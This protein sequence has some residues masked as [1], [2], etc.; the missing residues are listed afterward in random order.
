MIIE[1]LIPAII[2]KVSMAAIMQDKSR[3]IRDFFH[4]AIPKGTIAL[5]RPAMDYMDSSP[6]LVLLS[7][8]VAIESI[9]VPNDICADRPEVPI[10]HRTNIR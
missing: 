3:V 4:I 7:S 2:C 10:T 9:S 8:G 1:C 6:N 5:H